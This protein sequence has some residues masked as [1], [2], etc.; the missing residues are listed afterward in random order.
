MS[1]LVSRLVVGFTVLCAVCAS[2]A[3]RSAFASTARL[4]YVVSGVGQGWVDE[5]CI[6]NLTDSNSW[7]IN[8]EFHCDKLGG[9]DNNKFIANPSANGIGD[10]R[11]PYG[12]NTWVEF[13]GLSSG[14]YVL[15]A[16]CAGY[17]Q[18]GGPPPWPTWND[19]TGEVNVPV[20]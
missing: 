12:D 15:Y 1:R 4:E 20:P 14:W 18:N 2:G 17:T 8:V 13:T 3:A 6:L 11:Y 10:H 7:W 16:L 5:A 19:S 9:G